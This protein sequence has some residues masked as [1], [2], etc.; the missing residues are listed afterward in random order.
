MME[1]VV[2][3]DKEI[4]D[5]TELVTSVSYT[6]KLNDGCSKL[7]FSFI[8]NDPEIENANE[9]KFTYEDLVF[10]G[11]IFKHVRNSRNEVTVTAYDQL[12]Y[13]KAKDIIVT[14][15]DTVTTLVKRMCN[16]FNFKSGTLIDTKY[17]LPSKAYDNITWLDIIYDSIKDTTVNKGEMYCLRDEGGSVCLRNVKDLGLDL[18]LGDESLCY[19]YE[20]SKSIDDDF[21]NQI[22]IY[23]KGE[24]KNTPGHIVTAKDDKSIK[25]YGLLQYFET[26]DSKN[27]SQAQTMADILLKLYNNETESLTLNCLGDPSV[28]AGSSFYGQI[29]DIKLDKKLIVRSATHKFIPDYTMQIEVAI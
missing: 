1:L 10:Y 16:Y 12:R 6:D 9:V 17:V 29:E 8:G 23:V 15:N 7:E 24:N 11:F 25:K 20:Y 18:V 21:Y 2:S 19:E 27:G 28:R 3:N 22:K 26:M 14:Q 4:Y 13:A 5:I